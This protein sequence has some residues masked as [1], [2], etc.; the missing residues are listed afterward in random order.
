MY[1]NATFSG[2]CGAGPSRLRNFVMSV[3]EI[4]I[5]VHQKSVLYTSDE[6]SRHPW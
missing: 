4:C 2:V 3:I 1:N 5:L 6:E